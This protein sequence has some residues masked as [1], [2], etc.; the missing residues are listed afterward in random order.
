MPGPADATNRRISDGAGAWSS[1]VSV[2]AHCLKEGSSKDYPSSSASGRTK[3]VFLKRADWAAK[4]RR[5]HTR[6]SGQIVAENDSTFKFQGI[7]R[8]RMW[9]THSSYL[10][11]SR[12]RNKF[13]VCG[14]THFKL[15]RRVPAAPDWSSWDLDTDFGNLPSRDRAHCASRV[16]NLATLA[17]PYQSA[18][19]T[20]F[21]HFA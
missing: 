17:E 12:N 6:I 9:G 10:P 21:A 2:L 11:P 3:R 20:V 18:I 5:M 15:W 8:P 1:S 13:E 16:C 4:K 19:G 7:T 14:M